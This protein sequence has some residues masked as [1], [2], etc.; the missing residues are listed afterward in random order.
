MNTPSKLLAGHHRKCDELFAAAEQ[1]SQDKLWPACMASAQGFAEELLA[2]FAVE[3]ASL[4]PAFEQATGMTAGPTRMMRIEHEQMRELVAE[5]LDAAQ[6][7]DQERFLDVSD[8]LLVLMEQHN[9][10]EENVLYPMCDQAVGRDPALV[11]QIEN[12]VSSGRVTQ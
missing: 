10:K 7:E 6:A 11:T 12:A 3:E 8:T 4:F 5:L 2:H 1:Q 9:L